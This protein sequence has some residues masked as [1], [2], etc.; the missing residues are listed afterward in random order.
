MKHFFPHAL[1]H[2]PIEYAIEYATATQNVVL[3][4]YNL[5]VLFVYLYIFILSQILWHYLSEEERSILILV[6]VD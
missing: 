4:L 3:K 2:S 6:I 1:S 5:N